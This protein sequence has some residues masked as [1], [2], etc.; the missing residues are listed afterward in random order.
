MRV[1]FL[2]C[3]P[4]R[5]VASLAEVMTGKFCRWLGPSSVSRG[6]TSLSVTPGV[7]SVIEVDPEPGVVVDGVGED[8][9][10]CSLVEGITIDKLDLDAA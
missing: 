3:P 6:A 1:T 7:V 8:A 2:L 4:I 10:A 5:L 9:V